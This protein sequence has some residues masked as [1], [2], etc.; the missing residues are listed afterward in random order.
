MAGILDHST[1]F[2]PIRLNFEL[3]KPNSLND[4]IGVGKF[5]IPRKL[6]ISAGET[7]DDIKKVKPFKILKPSVVLLLKIVL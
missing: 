4:E 7:W 1:E 6:N 5:L 2:R 3:P